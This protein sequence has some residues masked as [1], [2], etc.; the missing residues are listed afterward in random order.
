MPFWN[1]HYF[2]DDSLSLFI[3]RALQKSKGEKETLDKEIS[4]AEETLRE[5]KEAYEKVKKLLEQKDYSRRR[6]SAASTSYEMINDYKSSTRYR[7]REETKN[8]L[9]FIHGGF[10]ASLYGAWDFL[11]ANASNE[12]MTKLM[13]S[14]KRG[15]F[16]QGI[17]ERAINDFQK[18]EE[19]LKQSVALK[20]Q[21]YLS[22][23]KY[24]LV[25]KTQS[26][27][28]NAEKE[29]W[30]PRNIKCLGV[31]LRLP[32]LSFS[33]DNVDKFVKSLDIG[34]VTQIPGVSGVSRTVT[35]L[36]FMIIDLHLRV[37][38]LS[39]KL[40]WFNENENHFIFQ[41]SDDGAPETN[42]L[43]MSIGSMVCWNFGDQVR[44]RDFQYL[45]HCVSVKEK[46]QI[47]HDLWKQ[48]TEEMKMLEGNV[49]TVCD[50]ECTVEFQPGADM[51]W[52]SWA[53]NEL[54]QAATY[55]SP[56]ANVH[57]GNMNTMGGSIGVGKDDTWKPYTMEMRT[58]NTEK[59]NNFIASLPPNLSEKNKNSR[60]LQFMAENGIRQLGLPRIGHF[61]D[62]LRPE[63]MHCEINAWQHYIDLLYLE[64]VRRG[65]FDPFVSALAAPIGNRDGDVKE[66]QP[67][68]TLLRVSDIDSVGERARKQEM[69]QKSEE[70]LKQYLQKTGFP[71]VRHATGEG[72][73]WTGILG[74]KSKRTF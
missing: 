70:D 31:D 49:L 63:P 67:Q 44:S 20:Y 10:E 2:D 35:G 9:E 13:S 74:F 12:T 62:K 19:V 7:R 48:H 58:S 1:C 16:L 52:Q 34:H 66:G 24:N 68:K 18:S 33:D 14:Y 29:V 40:V 72:G 41:F 59:V 54:N 17:F 42:E 25:C 22:R 47:M 8:I 38:H 15:R 73:V 64:A 69:L 6:R 56:Y 37:P 23:R 32:K 11:A 26:S 46:D 45:L 55:P 3:E 36:V 5:L 57:K 30:L 53:A 61:A 21:S 39:R 60:K 51:S 50:K 4:E 65:K 28:F 27:F 43:T 71:H